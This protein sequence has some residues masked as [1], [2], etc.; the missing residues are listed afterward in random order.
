MKEIPLVNGGVTLVDDDDYEALAFL[1]WRW[2]EAS[3]GKRYVV[4]TS[5]KRTSMHRRI[6]RATR[7][8]D[9]DHI[10]GDTFDNQ[11]HNLR[12]V[13]H[14]QNM[15][16]RKG[17]TSQSKSGLRGVVWRKGRQ[18]Y[19]VVVHVAGKQYFCGYYADRD[20]A[21][22]AAIAARKVLMT[23]ANGR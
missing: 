18:A 6:T 2:Q 22:A 19:Q 7:G 12:V 14:A 17:A 11:K 4:P 20:E 9:V 3:T 1:R 16:N 13:T 15:Q 8:W 23:H 5:G 21:E 10:N